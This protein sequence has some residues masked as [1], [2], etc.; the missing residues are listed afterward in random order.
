VDNSNPSSGL[1]SW[2]AWLFGVAGSGT[3]ILIY[4]LGLWLFKPAYA[5]SVRHALAEELLQLRREI[6]EEMENYHTE[7]AAKFDGV[8][9]RVQAQMDAADAHFNIFRDEVRKVEGTV[10]TLASKVYDA[11]SRISKIEGML[12]Q[13]TGGSSRR[14]GR[15]T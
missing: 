3:A 13:W 8:A 14:S 2:L 7:Q 12:Q 10:L 11:D 5:E 6:T 15:M 1:P 9:A 4:R